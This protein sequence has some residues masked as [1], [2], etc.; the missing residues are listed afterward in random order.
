MLVAKHSDPKERNDLLGLLDFP[1]QQKCIGGNGID[2]GVHNWLIYSGILSK[3]M[4]VQ[5]FSQGEGPINT[6][7]GLHG[8]NKL[9]Q[10]NMTEVNIFRQNL[11][12][13]FTIHNW[14]GDLSPVVH[15]YD[16]YEPQYFRRGVVEDLAA[17][18]ALGKKI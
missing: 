14:N 16:R 8:K 12:G 17:I 15:Q 18:K 11:K 13:I 7:G 4:K 1:P 9:I 2:Q 10:L 5:I 6:I 3:M